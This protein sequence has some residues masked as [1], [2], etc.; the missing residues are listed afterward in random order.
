MFAVLGMQCASAGHDRHGIHGLWAGWWVVEEADEPAPVLTLQ[1]FAASS[2]GVVPHLPGFRKSPGLI[3]SYTLEVQCSVQALPGR[4]A[5]LGT[6]VPNPV[7]GHERKRD[8]GMPLS[9]RLLLTPLALLGDLLLLPFELL[10]WFT[11]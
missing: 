5:S 11:P 3:P 8:D 7:L 10:W 6:A 4:P 9:S 2:I 1:C